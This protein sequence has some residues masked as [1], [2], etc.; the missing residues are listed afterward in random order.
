M[1]GDL[2]DYDDD[3]SRADHGFVHLLWFWTQDPEQIKRIHGDSGLSREKSTR[4][5]DYL[6]RFIQ[7]ASESCMETYDWSKSAEYARLP[8]KAPVSAEPHKSPPDP[9]IDPAAYGATSE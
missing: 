7:D 1:R 9:K 3:H 5:H 2:S 8:S 6:D 4:R